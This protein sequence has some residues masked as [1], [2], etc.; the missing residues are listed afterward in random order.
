[1]ESMEK[2]SLCT[3]TD[4]KDQFL[5]PETDVVGESNY[6]NEDHNYIQIVP[7]KAY[8]VQNDNLKRRLFHRK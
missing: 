8:C 3:E 4:I 1:M 6:I 5:D 2:V 7:K